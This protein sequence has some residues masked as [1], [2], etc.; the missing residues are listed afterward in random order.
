MFKAF[1]SGVKILNIDRF[2]EARIAGSF[3]RVR[4]GDRIQIGAMSVT[5]FD[6]K[7]FAYL[8]V[9]VH[10]CAQRFFIAFL[11]ISLPPAL[12]LSAQ[13]C[14]TLQTNKMLLHSCLA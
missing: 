5:A 13:S 4:V 7:V 9:S 2:T 11:S 6:A 8:Y 10:E 3:C 12:F 14:K 1:Q